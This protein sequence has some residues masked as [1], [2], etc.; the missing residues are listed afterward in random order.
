MELDRERKHRSDDELAALNFYLFILLS[1][2]H[3][4]VG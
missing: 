4:C 1:F 2:I 3:L